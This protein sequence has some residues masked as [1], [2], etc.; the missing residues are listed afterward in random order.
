MANSQCDPNLR[1][2]QAH[3]Y[4][5]LKLRREYINGSVNI[6]MLAT[7]TCAWATWLCVM[8]QKILI[9]TPQRGGIIVNP[10]WNI[11][12][13][14]QIVIIYLFISLG[15]D[16]FLNTLAKRICDTEKMK[17]VCLGIGMKPHHYQSHLTNNPNNINGAA[18]QS[19]STWWNKNEKRGKTVKEMFNE[20]ERV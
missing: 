17:D 9:H 16:W 14:F 6:R 11:F 20:F 15:K 2:V 19:F 3:W 7:R 1:N 4:L 10:S 18:F 12:V 8:V 13:G 5:H